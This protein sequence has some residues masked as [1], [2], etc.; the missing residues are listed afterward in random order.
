MLL[1]SDAVGWHLC[2][3][4]CLKLMIVDGNWNGTVNS[5][6]LTVYRRMKVSH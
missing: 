6:L 4:A 5:I 2:S 1:N 3:T